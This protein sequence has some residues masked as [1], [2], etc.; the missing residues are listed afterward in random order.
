MSHAT[1]PTQALLF[2]IGGVVIEVDFERALHSWA[3]LSRLSIDQMRRRLAVDETYQRYEKGELD[4]AVYFDH[5]R[6]I[7]ALDGSDA[8]IAAGWNAILVGEI[9]EALALIDVARRQL[10]C[11]AFSNTSHTHHAAWA[12]DYPRVVGAFEQLYLSFEIGQRKPDRSAFETVAQ[13]IGTNTD[14]ILFFDDMQENV[15]GA[16]AAGMQAVRVRSP[17][18]IRQALVDIGVL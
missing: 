17:A 9:S 11:F 7:F 10:P 13:Q 8:D 5:L 16:R 2:D 6:A 15:D 14:R 18:D 1:Y 12:A 4:A 3:P